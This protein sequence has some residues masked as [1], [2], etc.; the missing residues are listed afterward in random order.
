V[1]LESYYGFVGHDASAKLKDDLVFADHPELAPRD[2]FDR[3]GV[4]LE[5][6]DF[7]SQA[8]NVSAELGVVGLDLLE[9]TL[10]ST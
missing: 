9:L 5:L 6:L 4:F 7:D 1:D 10:Q 2:S 3:R 8:L